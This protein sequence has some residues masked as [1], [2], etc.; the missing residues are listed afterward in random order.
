MCAPGVRISSGPDGIRWNS[1]YVWIIC[2]NE[3]D[4]LDFRISQTLEGS[5]TLE[6]LWK[7]E[8]IESAQLAEC[9]RSDPLWELFI[10]R[11]VSIIQARVAKQLQI[12]YDNFEDESIITIDGPAIREGQRSLSLEL[13]ELETELLERAYGHLEEEVRFHSAPC[14]LSYTNNTLQKMKLAETGVVKRFL[15][16]MSDE[17]AT[18]E[19][20]S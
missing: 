14:A 10:L 11:A 3:E 2:A 8:T 12:L 15:A 1:D 7:G 5:K 9:C 17:A 18:D 19:D 16:S 20:F 4:G 13:R 6:V